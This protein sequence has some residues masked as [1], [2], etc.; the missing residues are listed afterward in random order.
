[1]DCGQASRRN[2]RTVRE[3]APLSLT[4]II[5][6]KRS[7]FGSYGKCRRICTGLLGKRTMKSAEE[8]QGQG[9]VTA[10]TRRGVL[11]GLA[12]TAAATMLQGRAFAAQSTKNGATTGW[13]EDLAATFAP[14]SL[15]D[16]W[17]F[18]RGDA[19]G[20]ED[21]SFDDSGWRLLDVPHDWS[22]EDLPGGESQG[23]STIWSE[24]NGP[25]K[26]GPF[27]MY[28]SEGQNATGWTVGGVGWY[29]K[30]FD[31]PAVPRG[32]KVELRFEG[33]YMNSEVWINGTHLGSHPYG[34]TS[35]LFDITPHLKDGKNAVAVKVNNTGQNSRWYSGSGIYRKV[36]LSVAGDLRLPEY[37]IDITTPEVSKD[38]A[39]VNINVIV[40]NSAAAN[41]NASVRVRLLCASGM[42]AGEGHV[43]ISVAAR[44][45]ATATCIVKVAVPKLWSP[46]EPNLY[47]AEIMVE[48]GDNV[49][50]AT[51]LNVG[52]RKVEI[53]AVGGLK[54]S[55]V[56]H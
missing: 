51:A 50:D 13:G 12:G 38:A 22:V 27:D 55:M 36:W 25:L 40:E 8:T 6:H 39:T 45:T 30:T 2:R 9:K 52:I 7:I 19:P 43:P 4:F 49:A 26:K 54:V 11:Q 47:R 18:H 44:T 16:A 23:E 37:G 20:A 14:R 31:K 15:C 5:F 10:I 35:F 1:M 32:G 53:D 28:A 29:R 46:A 42:T 21:G 24:G 56:I 48:S 3:P 33:V 34:Y 17:R 41:R